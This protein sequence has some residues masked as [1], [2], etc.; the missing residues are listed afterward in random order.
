MKEDH[1]NESKAIYFRLSL[2]FCGVIILSNVTYELLMEILEESLEVQIFFLK[3]AS[4]YGL[5]T[6]MGMNI[7]NI[8]TISC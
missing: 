3:R 1:Y 8:D 2:L 7:V 5:S 6:G 4:L